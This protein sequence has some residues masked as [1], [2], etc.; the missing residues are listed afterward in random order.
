LKIAPGGTLSSADKWA[1]KATRTAERA[2]LILCTLCQTRQVVAVFARIEA[3]SSQLDQV[4]SGGMP[5]RGRPE[6]DHRDVG[7]RAMPG[8]IAE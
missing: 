8:A 4:R 3:P 6:H 1:L 5:D 7:G 2:D